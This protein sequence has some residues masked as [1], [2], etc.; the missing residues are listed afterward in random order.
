MVEQLEGGF[1][2]PKEPVEI[3]HKG[4]KEPTS[5]TM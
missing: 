1:R 3:S 2:Q 4:Q 5:K